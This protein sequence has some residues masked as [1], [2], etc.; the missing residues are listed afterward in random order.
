MAPSLCVAS[1][2]LAQSGYGIGK[3]VLIK[4]FTQGMI[5]SDAKT[6]IHLLDFRETHRYELFPEGKELVSSPLCSCAVSLRISRS[7]SGCFLCERRQGCIIL[8]GRNPLPSQIKI[9]VDLTDLG[10]E[11]SHFL[12]G[13]FVFLLNTA[14]GCTKVRGRISEG[15]EFMFQVWDVF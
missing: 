4:T 8:D 5:K 1:P 11:S 14:L 6:T 15:H 12:F 13:A 7:T 3:L 2:L 10:F 9:L